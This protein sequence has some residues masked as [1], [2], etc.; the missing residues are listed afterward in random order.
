LASTYKPTK[1]QRIFKSPF[2]FVTDGASNETIKRTQR[3]LTKK[4]LNLAK[5]P[6]DAGNKVLQF[7][8]VAKKKNDDNSDSDGEI[9]K[10]D[11]FVKFDDSSSS[12]EDD[13]GDFIDENVSAFEPPTQKFENPSNEAMVSLLLKVFP[14]RQE[15]SWLRKNA[16]LMLLGEI[17]KSTYDK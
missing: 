1:K 5:K 6:A 9:S 10:R 8:D 14:F 13:I 17:T 16:A 7:L 4:L 3:K 11:S 15:H 2:D 12:S